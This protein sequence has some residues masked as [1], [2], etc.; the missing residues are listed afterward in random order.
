MYF[1]LDSELLSDGCFYN[2]VILNEELALKPESINNG[3][4][5]SVY[6]A[7]ALDSGKKEASWNR[8]RASLNLLGDSYILVSYFATDLDYVVVNG[9]AVS[10][11]DFILNKEIDITEKLLLLDKYWIAETKNQK[12]FLLTGAKGRFFFFKIEMNVFNNS[13]PTVSRIRI[14]F[15]VSGIIDYFPEFYRKPENNLLVFNRFLNIFQSLIYDL[16]EDIETVTRF[17]DPEVA[18]G[19]M[20]K[21]LAVWLSVED[22]YAWSEEQLKKLLLASFNFYCKKGAIG[23]ISA[24]VEF[25]TGCKPKIIETAEIL[26]S[27]AES[28]YDGNFNKLFGDDIYSFH[29][30][31]QDVST[32]K[33]VELKRMVDA[34]KPANTF[35]N[36]VILSPHMILGDHSYLGINSVVAQAKAFTLT[37]EVILPFNTMI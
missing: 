22:S 15:D 13:V 7:C 18:T 25:C 31:V 14:D 5:K 3:V 4:G 27:F 16:Q 32:K 37:D 9:V 26:E 36:I 19:E 35:A 33:L 20:L 34:F 11:N 30:L 1:V 29:I 17:L 6:L 23:G 10:L 2:C 12:D 8:F 24:V 21:S 28:G